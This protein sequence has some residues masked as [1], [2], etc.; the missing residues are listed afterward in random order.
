MRRIKGKWGFV[1]P[2]L[3]RIGFIMVIGG[4]RFT[5]LSAAKSNNMIRVHLQFF[6][7]KVMRKKRTK[8]F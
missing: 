1:I 5:A 3:L 4:Y 7:L 2:L 8:Q 6:Y